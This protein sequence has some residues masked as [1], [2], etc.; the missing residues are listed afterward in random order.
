MSAAREGRLAYASPN[1][2]ADEISSRVDSAS[3]N[4]K[5]IL[6]ELKRLGSEKNRAGM[7]RFGINTDKA[8]GI[9]MTTLKPIAKRFKRD[10]AL[11]EALW[12]SGYHEARLLAVLIEDPKQV[13]PTQMDAWV[14]DFDSWDVCDQACMR[15]FARTPYVTAKVKRWARDDREFV[16]R[17][18]FAT[19][20]GYT[21]HAKKAPDEAYLAFLPIIKRYATDNRNFVRKA[22]NWALRQIG[23]HS[24]AL[25][26]PALALAE[27]LAASED[28]SSRW[29]GRDA[30][31]E[32]TDPAQL[33]RLAAR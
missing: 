27:E 1:L 32:L 13:T 23:K 4:P 30:V 3:A 12:A 15:V 17:A 24:Q 14:A 31:K 7:A 8:F 16:R 22:V 29:I 2:E 33:E 11:A 25:H 18:A 26:G 28:K 5:A 20:A 19:I 6:A 9:S 10:H 21:V